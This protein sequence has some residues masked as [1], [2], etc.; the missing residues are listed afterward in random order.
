MLS[1]STKT[2]HVTLEIIHVQNMLYFAVGYLI[3]S[4][5]FHDTTNNDLLKA[6]PITIKII[7]P[8]KQINACLMAVSARTW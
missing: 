3:R 7:C 1:T 6:V 8:F 2:N 4:K 5:R